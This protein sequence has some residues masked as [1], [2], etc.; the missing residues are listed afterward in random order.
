M[1]VQTVP[2]ICVLGLPK[3]GKSDLCASLSAKTGA[4]HLK[5]NEIIDEY[6][7]RDCEQCNRLRTAM[8]L[9]GRGIDDQLMTA[10]LLKRTQKRDC[11]SRGWIVEDFPKTRVQAT[12]MARSGMTPTNVFLLRI[13]HVEVY[14]RTESKSK[15]DFECNRTILASR[16][17]CF[18]ANLP[19]VLSFF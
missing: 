6:I 14:K 12:Y 15:E 1:D 10:L 13:S 3:S 4:V 7:D 17:R 2:K 16:L 19:H 18:E 11:L 8:K 9:E 5:M